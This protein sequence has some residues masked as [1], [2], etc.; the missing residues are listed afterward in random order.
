MSDEAKQ[1]KRLSEE[2]SEDCR[3]REGAMRVRVEYK[4]SRV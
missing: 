1:A 4:V 3:E 2:G